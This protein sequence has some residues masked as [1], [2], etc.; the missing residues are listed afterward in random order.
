MSSEQY[1]RR[2][3]AEI[4]VQAL[5]NVFCDVG[6]PPFCAPC[7]TGCSGIDTMVGGGFFGGELVEVFGAPGSGRTQLLLG[8]AV[9][10]IAHGH[11][12]IY[13]DSEGG[14]LAS[15]VRE[16]LCNF[17]LEHHGNDSLRTGGSRLLSPLEVQTALDH[18]LV[19]RVCSWDEL[20]AAIAQPL[21]DLVGRCSSLKMIVLDSLTSTFRLCEREKAPKRLELLTGRLARVAM[22][23]NVVV[24]VVNN[25][26]RVT[27]MTASPRIGGDHSTY[28][29]KVACEVGYAAMGDTWA[30]ACPYRLGLGWSG[31]KRR[32]ARLIKSSRMPR[33]RAFFNITGSGASDL[34]EE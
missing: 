6:K 30:Y 16:I 23:Y 21:E 4:E 20:V 33:G 24:F 7:Q 31:D 13:I 1:E 32:V 17:L 14:L 28:S 25:S 9:R 19:I 8:T 5:G 2:C 22:L 10:A 27:A 34:P 11:H 18:L 29:S 12:V 15:R 3:K 26:R